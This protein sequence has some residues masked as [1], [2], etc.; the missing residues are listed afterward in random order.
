MESQVVARASQENE[1]EPLMGVITDAWCN[2]KAIAPTVE[3]FQSGPDRHSDKDG[4][5]RLPTTAQP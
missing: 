4:W 2:A 5:I 1:K 3:G